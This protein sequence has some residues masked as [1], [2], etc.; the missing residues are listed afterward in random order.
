MQTITNVMEGLRRCS[1]I[2]ESAQ[3]SVCPYNN[4]DE[5]KS[6]MVNNAIYYLMILRDIQERI[7]PHDFDWLINQLRIRKLIEEN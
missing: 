3:C 4:K 1:L 7:D 6:T 2:N 5:C